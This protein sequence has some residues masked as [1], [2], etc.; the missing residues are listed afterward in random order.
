M[1]FV[2]WAKLLEK[3]KKTISPGASLLNFAALAGFRAAQL[4]ERE[5]EWVKFFAK[6]TIFL[7]MLILVQFCC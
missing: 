5:D 7:R 3:T 6:G 2:K 1:L 4:L